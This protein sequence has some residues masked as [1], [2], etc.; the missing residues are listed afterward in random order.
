MLRKLLLRVVLGAGL[1]SA[2]TDFHEDSKPSAGSQLLRQA[3]L[4]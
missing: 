4:P 2:P 3:G 1:P